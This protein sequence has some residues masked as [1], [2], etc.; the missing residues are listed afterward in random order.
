MLISNPQIQILT[1]TTERANCEQYQTLLKTSS[2]DS[3]NSGSYPTPPFIS[4]TM[5]NIHY[6]SSLLHISLP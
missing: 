2:G 3:S 6:Y 1:L 5:E 4:S